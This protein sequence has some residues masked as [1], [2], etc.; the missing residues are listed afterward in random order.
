MKHLS[1]II[2]FFFLVHFVYGQSPLDTKVDFNFLE[3]TYE[4]ALNLLVKKSE[5]NIVF[6]S[7][8][9]PSNKKFTLNSKGKTV[10]FVLD[11]LIKNE[12]LS[13]N[14]SGDLIILFFKKPPVK[15]FRLSGYIQD[16]NTGERLFA[17]NVSV[18]GTTKGTSSNNYGF[19]SINLPAEKV[20]VNFSYLGYQTKQIELDLTIDQFLN[21]ELEPSITLEPVIVTPMKQKLPWSIKE[22]NISA[23]SIS[24]QKLSALPT[25]LGESDVIRTTLLLPGVTSAA[26]GIGGIHV[27]GGN[28]DQ[29]LILLDGV[30]IYNPFHTVGLFSIFNSNVVNN[31]TLLKGAFP[32]RYGGR[33]SSVLDVRTKEGNNKEIAGEVGVGLISGKGTLEGPFLG[34]KGSFIVSGRR[35]FIDKII[36][37]QTRQIKL[38]DT[39]NNLQPR[40]G[41]SGYNFYDLNLKASYNFSDKD[42]IYISY[43]RGSDNFHDEEKQV[44]NDSINNVFLFDSLSQDLGWGNELTSFRWNHLF[45][46]RLFLNTTITYSDFEFA[47]SLLTAGKQ[48][49][50]NLSDFERTN[51]SQ[52]SSTITDFGGRLD[53]DYAL[54][55]KH[56]MKFGGS[57]TYHTFTPGVGGVFIESV[58]ADSLVVLGEQDLDSL[59]ANSIVQAND[60]SFYV[61]DEISFSPQFKVNMGLHFTYFDV[62]DQLYMSMQPRLAA[63]YRLKDNFQLKGSFGQM[64]QHLHVL[65]NSNFGLPNDLWVPATKNIKP[66]DS[67]QGVLGFDWNLNRAFTLQV[68]SYYKQME[69]LISYQEGAS[70]LIEVGNSTTGGIRGENWENKVTSGKGTA[71]GAEIMLE[72]SVGRTNGWLSYVYAQSTRHFDEINNGEIYAY[73]YDRRHNVK[74]AITHY[75]TPW[76]QGNLNWV[77][78]TGIATTLP[79]SVIVFDP[80]GQEVIPGEP[81]DFGSKNSTRLPTYHRL[82]GGFNFFLRKGR[83]SHIFNLGAYNIYNR[84]NPLYIAFRERFNSDAVIKREFVEVSLIQFLPSFSY[85][86]KF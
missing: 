71:Y 85:T 3:V 27:R 23:A 45:N 10:K 59:R 77:F 24:A 48:D 19:Y 46:N 64:R 40:D 13:Y 15:N 42:K 79:R 70:F 38:R 1:L 14:T 8:I 73:R 66:Q 54:S 63:F 26:D 30:P 43:Y 2:P 21:V 51:F 32:A 76:L 69:N 83:L 11:N 6:S 84:R 28:P 86:L 65:S 41:F 5:L 31:A 74:F 80:P 56:Q 44:L 81:I 57:F 55:D 53:F 47:S 72:K 61:E 22:T 67:W 82:D 20:A 7:D 52:F 50:G 4:E 36:E 62:Q 33:I 29:N 37:N 9:L 34:G 12:P 68:E 16:K 49:A 39:L 60:L 18:A 35:T 58:T 78:S 17:G 25:F 75:F